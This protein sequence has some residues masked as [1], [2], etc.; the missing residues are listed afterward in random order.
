MVRCIV[1]RR[2]H[3]GQS[4]A[5][6]GAGTHEHE[7]ALHVGMVNDGG[8]CVHAAVNWPALDAVFG[9]LHGFLVSPLSNGNA[10]N[11]HGITRRIH[12]DEHVLQAAVFLA[13]QEANGATV[14]AIL[15]D[16]CGAGLDAHFVLNAHAVHIVARTHTAIGIDQ[17]LRHHKQADALHAFGCTLHAGQDQM[18]NVFGHVVFTI[19]D[20]DFG[21]KNFEAAIGQWLCTGANQG[22][23]GACLRFGQ[24]HGACPLAR[25]EFFQINAFQFVRT[26]GEQGLNGTVCEHGAQRKTHVGR[27][28]DFTAR[29]ANGFGQTLTTK[30]CGM[31]QALPA[32]FCILLVRL[33]ETGRCG[34]FAL[35]KK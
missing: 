34:H 32:G 16:G 35:C 4:A 28:D 24:I 25:N 29:R 14:V 3:G 13:H 1:C 6:L 2:G 30:S 33:F 19:G 10:L 5:T 15:Q 23:I 12:H 26:G 7:H 21:A 18:H 22:Q 9:V 20:V 27:V 8:R 11:A 31:L 17:K